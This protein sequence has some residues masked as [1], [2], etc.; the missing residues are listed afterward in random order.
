MGLTSQK[1]VVT[2][3][4]G[5]TYETSFTSGFNGV[6]FSAMGNHVAFLSQNQL[7]LD[8]Q[9]IKTFNEGS[10]K[11]CD[12]FVNSDG[13]GA[14]QIKNNTISFSDGDY[15]EYPLKVAIVYVGGKPY[16]KWMALENKEVVVYQKP[17]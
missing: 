16:Y 1:Y 7:Y 9:I 17:Y 11:A 3:S 4:T 8:G 15:F 5:K 13:K 2:T 12:L 14:T 6:W 10:P